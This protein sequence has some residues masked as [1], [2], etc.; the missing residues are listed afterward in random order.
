MIVH[1]LPFT[2]VHVAL[3]ML[4]L[5][6]TWFGLS[7][8]FVGMKLPAWF[9]M[10]THVIWIC[11][12]ILNPIKIAHQVNGL[13]DIG[14]GLWWDIHDENIIAA[15]QVIDNLWLLANMILPMIQSGY[16]TM[17]GRKTHCVTLRIEDNRPANE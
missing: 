2:N 12:T 7:V 11:Q 3:W 1:S 4:S 16:L 9:T 8:A 17:Q 14:K 5:V 10:M 6:V 15:M 13:G